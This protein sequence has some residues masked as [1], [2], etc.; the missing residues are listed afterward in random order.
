[1]TRASLAGCQDIL[2]AL[3][4]KKE[5]WRQNEPF[6]PWLYA[7]TRYKIID[8]FRKRGRAHY[9]DIEDVAENLEDKK[10]HE[11]N[12]AEQNMDVQKMVAQLHGKQGDIVRAI[13]IEGKSITQAA[14]TFNM[15]ET[16][17]RVNFHRGLEKLRK[18]RTYDN[19]NG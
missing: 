6:K 3:H 5:T 17:V 12:E 1:M 16:A 18:L 9:V 10:A 2:M 8:A 19:E 11:H 14:Q 7:I 15:K 13:G 4:L